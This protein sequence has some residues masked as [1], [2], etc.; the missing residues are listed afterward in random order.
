RASLAQG[1]IDLGA[2]M[3][4]IRLVSNFA[5]AQALIGTECPDILLSEFDLDGGTCGLDLMS[6]RRKKG[7]ISQQSLFILVTG[8]NS[9]AAVARAAEED[10]DGYILKPYTINGL[11]MAI[12]KYA[13]D[14]IYPSE[15]SLKIEAGKRKLEEKEVDSALALFTE[16]MQLD[17]KPSLAY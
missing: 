2:S 15:Y 7:G 4:Q 11:R 17:A 1:L 16:A 12:M 9:Q 5:E 14:K 6:A 3:H 8:N 13:T 10:V